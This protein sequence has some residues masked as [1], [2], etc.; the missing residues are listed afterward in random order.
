[1]LELIDLDKSDGNYQVLLQ[2]HVLGSIW[3]AGVL[4]RSLF[5]PIEGQQQSPD[6]DHLAESRMSFDDEPD[7][8]LGIPDHADALIFTSDSGKLSFVSV[9]STEVEQQDGGLGLMPLR[10]ESVYEVQ[11]R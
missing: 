1:V 11:G 7:N 10:F 6:H 2:Q 9:R 5:I 3:G 8:S 4:R